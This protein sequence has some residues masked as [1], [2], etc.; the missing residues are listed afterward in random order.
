MMIGALD[1][2]PE[3]DNGKLAGQA[4]MKLLPTMVGT[5]EKMTGTEGERRGEIGCTGEQRER[6]REREIERELETLGSDG[7]LGL[8]QRTACE[9]LPPLCL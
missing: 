6:E 2:N 9:C 8:A 5:Y 7:V 4:L 3:A 1:I